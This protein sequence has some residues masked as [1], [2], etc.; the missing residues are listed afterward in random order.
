MRAAR[1]GRLRSLI[2]SLINFIY[3]HKTVTSGF[4]S[5]RAARVC[6]RIA[7]SSRRLITGSSGA[8]TTGLTA[9]RAAAH[10][11]DELVSR[12]TVLFGPFRE[13]L[14]IHPGGQDTHGL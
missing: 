10:P 1:P 3:R 9:S 11:A 13:A 2:H 14:D 6:A 5:P 4:L 8:V 12:N 7:T